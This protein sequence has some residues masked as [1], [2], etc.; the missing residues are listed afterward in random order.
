MDEDQFNDK[1]LQVTL[2]NVTKVHATYNAHSGNPVTFL[3]FRQVYVIS[4]VFF[5]V[6]LFCFVFVV[7]VVVAFLF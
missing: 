3:S 1:G 5:S 4:P 6:C 7:V 2:K